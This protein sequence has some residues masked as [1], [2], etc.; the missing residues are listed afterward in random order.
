MKKM[1][2]KLLNFFYRF[3]TAS[4][5]TWSTRSFRTTHASIVAYTHTNAVHA[6]SVQILILLNT[7]KKRRC[8]TRIRLKRFISN[9]ITLKWMKNYSPQRI[10]DFSMVERVACEKNR[11]WIEKN[12]EL[13]QI[14]ELPSSLEI[15]RSC[16]R[17]L[18]FNE[19]YST[20]KMSLNIFV[21]CG[22]ILLIDAL[23]TFNIISFF[24]K[25][26]RKQK[27]L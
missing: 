10:Q 7:L 17:S 8:L 6:L 26:K 23:D 12:T 16:C 5:V 2:S 9:S 1:S 21:D 3:S 13:S 11:E 20:A 22:W 4:V 18:S 15:Q 27:N 19:I 24:L 25:E 14:L